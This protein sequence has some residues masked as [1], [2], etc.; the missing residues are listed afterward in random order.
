M[1]T[2]SDAGRALVEEELLHFGV[3]GMRWGVRKERSVSTDVHTD[4]GIVKRQTKVRAAG[5]VSHPATDD[6][7]KA[8]VQ[9]QKLKKSGAA[10]LS[11]QELRDLSTRLQLEAQVNNLTSKKGRRFAQRQ[12]ENAGQ[13]TVQRG[14]A[15]ATRRGTK[16][17]G[18][19]ALL[20]A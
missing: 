11:N 5:G 4:T 6:A 17:V 15:E 18:G 14:L 20:F 2:T 12:L 3:K 1:S 10:A 8:A 13:Q 16:K 19:A 9:Q 7:I